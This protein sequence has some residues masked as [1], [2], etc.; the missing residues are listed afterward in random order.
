[1]AVIEMAHAQAPLLEVISTEHGLSQGFVPTICQDDDGFL[2][3][4]TK[5]GLNRYD[6]YD[7]QVFKNDPFDSLS[8][9]NNEVVS[10]TSAGDFLVV[11][12]DAP[13]FM[14]FERKSHRFFRLPQQ[15]SPKGDFLYKILRIGPQEVVAVYR[16]EDNK[17]YQLAH[18]RWDEDF[19]AQASKGVPMETLL[20]LENWDTPHRLGDIIW[21]ESDQSLLVLT[22]TEVQV[23]SL[24]SGKVQHITFP[25]QL[26]KSEQNAVRGFLDEKGQLW[27]AKGNQLLRFDGQQWAIF[28]L[29]FSS[30]DFH[31]LY[32]NDLLWL[33]NFHY[34]YGVYLSRLSEPVR[35]HY[36]LH[37]PEVERAILTD[38]TGNVWIGTDAH[39]IRKFNPRTN[40]FTNFLEG[41]S[42]YCKPAEYEPGKLFLTDVRKGD[43]SS[44]T[45]DRNTSTV[46]TFDWKTLTDPGGFLSGTATGDCNVWLLSY[47]QGARLLRFK[48]STGEKEWFV[49]PEQLKE[50][51][52]LMAFEAPDQFWIITSQRFV[53]FNTGSHQFTFFDLPNNPAQVVAAQRSADGTWWVATT[54][55]LLRAAPNGPDRFRCTTYLPEP[56]NRNSLPTQQLKS[57]L[58]DPADPN[59]LWIGTNGQGMSRLDIRAKRFTHFS[60][61]NGLPD[62]VVYGI[63]ADDDTPRKLWISTNRGLAR[64]S[65]ETG[66][67]Q[68]FTH[69]DGLPGDEFNTYA[70]YK[71]PTGELY[72]GGIN[73]L[74]VFDPKRL[75]SAEQPP[76][77]RFTSL[78]INGLPVSPLDSGAAIAHDISLLQ[79]LE[80]PFSQNNLSI[81]FASMDFTSPERN[82]FA[83]YLEGAETEWAHRGFEHTAQYLNLA[84][85]TYT[86]WVKTANS[87]GVWNEQPAVLH[88]VVLAPWYRT[89]WAYLLYAALLTAATYAFYWMRLRNRLEHAE[90]ERLKGMDEF[91]NR[92]F[93]NI[94][95]EFRTPLT[96]IL[97]M[98]ERLTADGERR[99]ERELQDNLTLIK[100]NG[101]SLLRLINQMLDLA[102]LESGKMQLYLVQ[103]DV[104]VF[105]QYLTESFRSFAEGKKIE[106]HF[107]SSPS[108]VEALAKEGLAPHALP[109]AYDPEKIQAIVSNLLSNALKF[110]PESGQVYVQAGWLGE[111][112]HSVFELCVRDTGPGI[113]PEK[114]PHVFDRFYQA[115]T[116]GEWAGSGIGLA[117]VK[118]LAKLM[119]GTVRAESQM[120][121]GAVFTVTLPA[122]FAEAPAATNEPSAM[123]LFSQKNTPRPEPVP[124]ATGSDNPDKPLLLLVEDNDDVRQYLAQ[125]LR[126]HYQLIESADGQAGI[127]RALEQVPDL[128]ISDVM[129]PK[130]DGFELCHTLKHDERTSH[131]PIVLLT[132]KADV[133]SRIEGLTRGA[134]DYL[135]KPFERLELLARVRNLLDNRR[136]LQARYGRSFLA[137]GAAPDAPDEVAV[138]EDVFLQKLRD[139]VAEHLNDAAFDMNRL[140]RAV[141]MS[142]SQIF[143]K[144]KALTGRSPSN[145][146]RSV[147]LHHA[148]HLLETTALTA[149]EIAYETGFTSP[150]YFS[151][152]FLEEFGKT[153][154]EA[155]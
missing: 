135:A 117:L 19:A 36:T 6:G 37:I 79:R 94:T 89:W 139:I 82:Q 99:T 5:N 60:T 104:A 138:V 8:L 98:A 86:F 32:K 143:R 91:K 21:R 48:P 4:G 151:T 56:G 114:L 96:V 59:V 24:P 38:Q 49:L 9:N 150:A 78:K 112:E 83:F 63:L 95:H 147:R 146:I 64:F 124:T 113:S 7:F 53:R 3:F 127:E 72:F 90:A 18:L 61:K 71:S 84:P 33:A 69:S 30:R 67:F 131:I 10:L 34:C 108:P 123:P 57:L 149:A 102:K 65:P 77:V 126:D 31:L 74:T 125:C 26:D 39:G 2:W 23:R 12:T 111:G 70:A 87:N 75:V 52:S 145:F 152:T 132:A 16:R 85:G 105:A 76:A 137:E 134:D 93:T 106:L 107:D 119:G 15:L 118:E 73:G 141:G 1:M 14:L 41:Q 88:L 92:F 45:L 122:L 11:V 58:L 51:V 140:S 68:Y 50:G 129:M 133:A 142:H 27:C 97:G 144:L 155:R 128:V 55:G 44:K 22:A 66:I 109:L 148:R 42:I 40:I 29:P 100:R 154:T 103:G 28:T 54:N 121:A 80:V 153:P 62:D 116:G 25:P 81:G 46:R 47:L 115:P 13:S 110:T 35:P 20:H 17:M 101:Q 136:R 120:G 43:P 130:K